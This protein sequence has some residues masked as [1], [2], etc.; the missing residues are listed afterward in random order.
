MSVYNIYANNPDLTPSGNKLPLESLKVDS[1]TANTLVISDLVLDRGSAAAPSLTFGNDTNTGFYSAGANSLDMSIS[2][3]PSFSLDL[4]NTNMGYRSLQSTVA[5]VG[6]NN[7]AM[8]QFAMQQNTNGTSNVAIGNSALLANTTGTNNVAVGRLALSAVT[9]AGSSNVAVGFQALFNTTQSNSVAVGA[10]A[11]EANTSGSTTAIGF[12]S[13]KS[14]TGGQNTSVGYNSL[15]ALTT[16]ANNTVMGNSAGSAAT[17][18]NNTSI[19]GYLAAQN[20]TGND[21]CAFGVSA[22]ANNSGNGNVA[23]GYQSLQNNDVAANNTA[24]GYVTLNANTLGDENTAMGYQALVLNTEGSRNVAIGSNSMIQ[25]LTGS[26]NTAVGRSA[27]STNSTGNANTAIGRAALSSNTTGSDNTALGRSANFASTTGSRNTCLGGFSGVDIT[28]GAN[29]TLIGYRSGLDIVTGIGNIVISTAATSP[30]AADQW[31]QIYNSSNSDYT[32]PAGRDGSVNF[33]TGV[34]GGFYADCLTN[35]NGTT[36]VEYNLAT[37]LIS[38]NAAVPS[39][40]RYKENIKPVSDEEDKQL[41]SKFDDVKMYYFDYK[42]DESV[43]A[44]F[45]G[46]KHN[47]GMIAEEINEIYPFAIKKVDGQIETIYYERLIMPLFYEVKALKKVI[48]DIKNENR[49]LIQA[50]NYLHNTIEE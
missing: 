26:E 10:S 3:E 11:A 25:N 21:I 46:Q 48:K 22:L 4:L 45:R 18:S 23:I 8:G 47:L 40:L 35:V 38:Y 20:N 32:L 31:T 42:D 33:K 15:L 37:G 43:I 16:G 9:T 30:N 44:Q 27:L 5:G 24:V 1:I 39:S 17:T 6:I 28:T 49:Q 12:Q 7:V 41:D 36:Y 29:N 19:F 13:Q 50:V 14:A 2:G 34:A